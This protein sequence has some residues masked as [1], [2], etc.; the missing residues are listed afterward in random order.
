MIGILSPNKFSWCAQLFTSVFGKL[1]G[2]RFIS[3]LWLF[4]FFTTFTPCL[5]T[6]STRSSFSA[7]LPRQTLSLTC[8][9]FFGWITRT[10]PWLSSFTTLPISSSIF[11]ALPIAAPV[12]FSIELSF[13]ATGNTCLTTTFFLSSSTPTS[14]LPITSFYVVF[15][16]ITS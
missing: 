7:R 14:F 3:W 11:C 16:I 9:H 6:C 13:S 4:S 12:S 1:T 15:K 5:P 8:A 2:C 10:S